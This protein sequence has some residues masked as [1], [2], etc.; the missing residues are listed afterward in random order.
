[1]FRIRLI[2]TSQI[3]DTTILTNEMTL[4]R[5]GLSGN[6]LLSA[7]D[8]G[9]DQVGVSVEPGGDLRGPD[10]QDADADD[11]DDG[12]D[13][14]APALVGPG[15]AAAPA[16]EARVV[17]LPT[18]DQVH[19]A[20]ERAR[21]DEVDE[22]APEEELTDDRQ[23]ERGV[24]DLAEGLDQGEEQAVEADED[25]PVGDADARPLE[26]PGVAERLDERRLDPGLERTEP[27]AV[28]L[29]RAD[30][31][32]HRAHGPIEHDR[33]HD[34]EQHADRAQHDLQRAR[35]VFLP[36]TPGGAGCSRPPRG[37][38]RVIIGAPGAARTGRTPARGSQRAA[39]PARPAR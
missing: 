29:A 4:T 32:H 31:A 16:T 28:G 34:Q 17:P 21:A 30:D 24:P 20:D 12:L 2:T 7:L 11:E 27:G 37:D 13:E 36:G 39:L 14:V 33:G 19:D 22:Q 10:A 23:V 1:M 18:Q 5:S 25:E 38:A 6:R 8:T 9:C 35:H 3:S 15:E 26:H